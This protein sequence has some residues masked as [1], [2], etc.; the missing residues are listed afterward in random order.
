[1]CLMSLFFFNDTA[2]TEIYTYGHTLSL[3]DALPISRP[4]VCQAARHGRQAGGCH[5][6][7]AIT[8]SPQALCLGRFLF[9][10]RST[11]AK[12]PAQRACLVILAEQTAPLQN[13]N[14][15]IYKIVDAARQ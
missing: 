9:G 8:E 13:R 11:Q 5:P 14:N 4:A 15:V 12:V 7:P 1:M 10:L 6:Q 3:H 2:T